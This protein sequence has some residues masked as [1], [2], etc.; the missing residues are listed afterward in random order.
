MYRDSYAKIGLI[1]LMEINPQFLDVENNV[2]SLGWVNAV[3]G[4][5]KI[6]DQITN[7]FSN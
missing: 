1:F 4:F 6:G 7:E 2:I 3:V 5:Y